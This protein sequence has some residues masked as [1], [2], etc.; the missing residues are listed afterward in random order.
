[1]VGEAELS[2]DHSPTTPVLLHK[3]SKWLLL[4]LLLCPC[5]PPQ[6]SPESAPKL[7][8]LMQQ[9]LLP[10]GT[11]SIKVSPRENSIAQCSTA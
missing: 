6:L 7:S 10:A 9:H 1:V 5:A 8:G 3:E 4:L 11:Q 2:A